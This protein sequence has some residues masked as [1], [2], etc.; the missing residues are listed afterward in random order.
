MSQLWRLRSYLFSLPTKDQ[1]GW[2][3]GPCCFA[4]SLDEV[5][6]RVPTALLYPLQTTFGIHMNHPVFLSV[7]PGHNFLTHCLIRVIIKPVIARD[8]R[9]RHHIDLKG[10]ISKVT[11]TVHKCRKSAWSPLLLSVMSDLNDISHNCW[12]CPKRLSC[13]CA[14]GIYPRAISHCTQSQNPCPGHMSY[15]HEGSG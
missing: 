14:N 7:C 13:S 6:Y 3:S 8:Q 10:H 11:V 15:C 4:G 12:P 2:A 1:R 9:V 5:I